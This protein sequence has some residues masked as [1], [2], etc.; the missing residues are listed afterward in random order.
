MHKLHRG[1]A[2]ACLSSYRHGLH[3][4]SAV[5]PADKE[6]IWQALQSMQGQY[7][8]YCECDISNG[9]RH[10]EHFRQKGRDA[11]QTFNWSNLF[12]SCLRTDSCGKF[13]DELPP[14]DPLALI[15]PDAEDPEE[16]LIFL[17]NG[18]VDARVGLVAAKRHRALET[19]R[20][21]NLNGSLRQIRHSFVSQYEAQGQEAA[22][23][24]AAG[25]CT[26]EDCASFFENEL[27]AAA[28]GP[29][30][31]AIRHTLPPF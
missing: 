31:T 6:L 16:F 11:T 8:A 28:N 2:P 9:R 23:M 29:F 20:I 4:W 12:G 15:K 21:F 30:V 3:N 27:A 18:A 5:T 19:I 26:I 14:Y 1:A 17:S 24:V 13:K 22:R 25:E 7:C 10:I